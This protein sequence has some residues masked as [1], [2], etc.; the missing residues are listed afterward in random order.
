MTYNCVSLHKHPHT[1]A[2][3]RHSCLSAKQMMLQRMSLMS[4]TFCPSLTFISCISLF[5]LSALF[6]RSEVFTCFCPL[7]SPIMKVLTFFFPSAIWRDIK[8]PTTP[9]S[10]ITGH[11][12]I[13]L[14]NKMIT[15]IIV[16]LSF[17]DGNIRHG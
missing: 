14:G 12:Y 2:V 17:R 3:H 5:S 9:M 4:H 16:K 10:S 11:L 6:C 15:V 1:D 13:L 8:A 7:L